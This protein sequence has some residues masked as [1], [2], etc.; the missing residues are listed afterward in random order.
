MRNWN[1]LEKFY[2]SKE[3]FQFLNVLALFFVSYIVHLKSCNL[4]Y[5]KNDS[6]F[7]SMKKKNKIFV[8]KI[9]LSNFTLKR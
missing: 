5:L 2:K 6:F 9:F 7:Y 8:F 3:S 4:N 1:N